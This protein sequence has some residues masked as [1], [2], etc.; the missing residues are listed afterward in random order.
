MAPL[1]GDVPRLQK[2]LR[3]LFRFLRPS[4]E[5][6]A[7][8]PAALALFLAAQLGASPEDRRSLNEALEGGGGSF[9]P[10]GSPVL[11]TALASVVAIGGPI[12]RAQAQQ[13]AA[14]AR[15]VAS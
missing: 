12:D 7:G 5:A 1:A 8:L 13:A 3:N 10:F 9:A 14:L 11:K 2:R 4:E 15:H 6:P